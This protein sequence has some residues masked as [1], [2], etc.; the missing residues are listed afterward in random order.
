MSVC[1][2]T[3]AGPS[4][5]NAQIMAELGSQTQIAVVEKVCKGAYECMGVCK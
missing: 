4:F 2:E 1:S 3:A 5:P